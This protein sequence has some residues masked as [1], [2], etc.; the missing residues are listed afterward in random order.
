MTVL[1]DM[2]TAQGFEAWL[3]RRDSRIIR[4]SLNVRVVRDAQG[5]VL[6]YEGTIEDITTRKRAEEKAGASKTSLTVSYS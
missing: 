2:L 4:A 5:T 3:Y 1:C 6:Y